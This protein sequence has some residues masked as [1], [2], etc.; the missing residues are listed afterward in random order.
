[1]NC[2]IDIVPRLLHF[3]RPAGTSRGTYTTRKVWYLHFTSPDFPGK[4]GIGECAPLPDLSCDALPDY[5]ERLAKA[6]RQVEKDRGELDIDALRDYPSILFGLETAVRHFTAGGWA[7]Y[8]TAFS[9]GEVGIP[10]N[11]LIWMGDF[12]NMLSQIEKKTEA[13]FRCIKLKIGAINFEEEL[14][15]LRH[16]RAHFSAKEI[17]LRVDANGAFSPADAME[18]LKRLSELD[19]HSIEQP[20]RAGQWEEMARLAS[21]SPL[22]IALDEELIGCNT[23]EEKQKLLSAIRPQYIIIKPSLHGGISGGNEWIAEAEKLQIGWWITSA[24]ESNIGLNAIAQWCATFDNPLPQG[25]G[26]GLLFT[27]NV[28]APLEI[29]K[30]CLWFCQ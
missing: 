12:D 13:G 6:C 18:K 3:K 19:L 28:E 27:D 22:P 23:R 9:R 7:L 30:D 10:I 29:R 11:G 2:K 5:E 21:E 25:L 20:V 17:E 15:L 4:K 1:M 26:T 16:I 24:L 14:A 8:D